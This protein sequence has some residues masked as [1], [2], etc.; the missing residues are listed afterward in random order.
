MKYCTNCGKQIDENVKFCPYCGKKVKEPVFEASVEDD[1]PKGNQPIQTASFSENAYVKQA[2]SYVKN[3]A[4]PKILSMAA[5]IYGAVVAI[6]AIILATEASKSDLSGLSGFF[7]AFPAFYWLGILAGV[8]L[9]ALAIYRYIHV[10]DEKVN[11][12][13]AVAYGINIILISQLSNL[14]DLSK[15]I[16]SNDYGNTFLY[17]LS[18]VSDLSKYKTTFILLIVVGAAICFFGFAVKRQMENKGKISPYFDVHKDQCDK[19]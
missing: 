6:F 2:E 1:A 11:L 17:G 7:K 8:A 5:M 12:I 10:K 13:Y 16:A 18:A 9:C 14:N 3:W 15:S 19:D 4:K